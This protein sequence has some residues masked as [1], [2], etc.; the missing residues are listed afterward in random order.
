MWVNIREEPFP[1]IP[2][3]WWDLLLYRDHEGRTWNPYFLGYYVRSYVV[4]P[5]LRRILN[6]GYFPSLTFRGAPYLA[7][8]EEA[9]A[10]LPPPAPLQAASAGHHKTQQ[11]APAHPAR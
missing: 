4:T 2:D 10:G 6:D 5:D 8:L 3:T 11:D 1:P 9:L 7:M